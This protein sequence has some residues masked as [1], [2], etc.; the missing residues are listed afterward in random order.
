MAPAFFLLA[1][2]GRETAAFHATP[3]S[4]QRGETTTAS[5]WCYR[6]PPRLE[7]QPGDSGAHLP[8]T[9]RGDSLYHREASAV[10]H[11][12]RC[13]QSD[14]SSLYLKFLA[15]GIK[16]MWEK[17]LLMAFWARLFGAFKVETSTVSLALK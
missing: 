14:V 7:A 9:T 12:S 16:C 3:T 1:E 5:L 4:L 13:T 2:E 17:V 11:D 10:G 6:L 8:M 15:M